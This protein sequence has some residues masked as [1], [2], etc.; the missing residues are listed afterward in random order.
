MTAQKKE[1]NLIA[2]TKAQLFSHVIVSTAK[3]VCY[4]IAFFSSWKFNDLCQRLPPTFYSLSIEICMCKVSPW[5]QHIILNYWNESHYGGRSVFFVA[6]LHSH[7]RWI[8]NRNTNAQSRILCCFDFEMPHFAY[9]IFTLRVF[10][11][12]LCILSLTVVAQFLTPF[13]TE[14]MIED[15]GTTI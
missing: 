7:N 8:S 9:G 3:S 6:C 10:K 2:K 1:L 14:M 13:P 12:A 11:V 4:V 5:S 15:G